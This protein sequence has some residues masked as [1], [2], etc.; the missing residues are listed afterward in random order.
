VKRIA[1][2][3]LIFVMSTQCL[4]KLGVLTYFH[5]NQEYV[6]EVLC[7]NK[8][9]PMTLC[10]GHC[11]LK[12]SLNLV[13]E[14]EQEPLPAK[15]GKEK[16]EIPLFLVAENSIQLNSN[17]SF[18]VFNRTLAK[19]VAAGHRSNPFRPPSIVG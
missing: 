7:I 19:S 4:Y 13:D 3:C 15:S 17:I 9:V 5:I 12:R 1:A 14:Q 8:E 16:F 11:Y 10:H 2:I 6:V 18:Q